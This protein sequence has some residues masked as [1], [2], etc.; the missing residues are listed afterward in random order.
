MNVH[1]TGRQVD[2]TETQKKKLEVKFQK[3]QKILGDRHQPEAHVILSL[4][5]HQFAAEATLN[6]HHH[7]LV[8]ECAGAELFGAVQGAVEK[9]EKQVIRNKDKW[10][11]QKRRAKPLPKAPAELGYD[12][13]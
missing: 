7:T 8:V 5:R 10:R 13:P 1:Y 4:Q 3:I 6:F 9:L 12:S 11:E 2:L